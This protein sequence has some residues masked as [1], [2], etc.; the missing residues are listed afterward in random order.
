MV[1]QRFLSY[2]FSRSFRAGRWCWQQARR[3]DRVWWW[4]VA[5]HVL[6][7]MALWLGA[8]WIWPQKPPMTTSQ[9]VMVSTVT[10]PDLVAPPSP[11]A[12]RHQAQVRARQKQARLKAAKARVI[13][14]Q[15][16]KR[17]AQLLAKRQAKARA[18]A[19]Q[20]AKRQAQALAEKKA[21]ARAVRLAQQRAQALAEKKAKARA[22]RLAEKRAEQLALQLAAKK[23]AAQQ[24]QAR[25][26]SVA[27]ARIVSAISSH[28]R[29][30]A[31]AP[32]Q[33]SCLLKIWLAPGGVVLQVA[34][35]RSSGMA[36]LDRSAVAAVY[37]AS[38]LPVPADQSVASMFRRF[39]LLVR[40]SDLV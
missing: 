30:P 26:L 21:K 24:M 14:R 8:I 19:R 22:A 16:A 36:A 3:I 35:V 29:V 5:C 20:Q 10:P 13:A 40:P 38:P 11:A 37:Q 12:I 25:A 33:A 1:S 2:W 31:D 18:V 27:Q 7:I 32:R 17:R 23:R 34:L 15:R 6:L 4:S 39:E 28:W 9:V